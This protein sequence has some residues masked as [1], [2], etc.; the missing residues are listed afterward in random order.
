MSDEDDE[1]PLDLDEPE[2]TED[3]GSPKRVRSKKQR[4][5]LA[6]READRFWRDVFA[7]P[8]GRQ[9]MWKLL[10]GCH[11]FEERFA[12]GPNGFPQTEATWFEAGQQS[13]GLRLYQ[14]WLARDPLAVAAMHREHDGRFDSITRDK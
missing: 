2:A 5:E 12:C 6:K 1:L 14:T 9:E 13:F 7:N 11:T 10:Q 3:A 4:L 8:V